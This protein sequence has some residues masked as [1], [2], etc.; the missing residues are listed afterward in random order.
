MNIDEP[1]KYAV[2]PRVE[3]TQGPHGELIVN[4]LCDG[5]QDLSESV[6]YPFMPS[7][8]RVIED[9]RAGGIHR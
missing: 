7:Q 5:A 3:R 4:L 2:G 8:G 6:I 1:S 9:V